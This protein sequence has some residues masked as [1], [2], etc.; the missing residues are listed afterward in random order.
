MT[1]WLAGL[2][3]LVALAA[4]G[5]YGPPMRPAPDL[6]DPAPEEEEKEPT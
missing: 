1:R 5:K 6:Q 4:C 2:L 3:L